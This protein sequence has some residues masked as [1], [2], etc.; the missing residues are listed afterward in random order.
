MCC[1][2]WVVQFALWCA[3]VYKALTHVCASGN[4][5]P[6]MIATL[7]SLMA[8]MLVTT[9]I[10]RHMSS[11]NHGSYAPS[12]AGNRRKLVRSRLELPLAAVH[13]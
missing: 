10:C 4:T 5:A 9:L 6:D 11:M 3:Q 2:G 13:A 8:G 7:E 1:T 12:E